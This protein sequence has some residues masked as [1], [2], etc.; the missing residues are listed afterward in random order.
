ME[1]DPYELPEDQREQIETALWTLGTHMPGSSHERFADRKH[2]LGVMN[3]DRRFQ[4]FLRHAHRR[5]EL[6]GGYAK[7]GEFVQWLIGMISDHRDV[8][9]LFLRIAILVAF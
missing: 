5:Y 2:L 7:N 1:G 4:F 3:D 9:I 8:I 6:T